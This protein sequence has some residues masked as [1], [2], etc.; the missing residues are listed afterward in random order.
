MVE[1]LDIITESFIPFA[2]FDHTLATR[3]AGLREI[4][5]RDRNENLPVLI[6]HRIMI[7]RKRSRFYDVDAISYDADSLSAAS[8]SVRKS[9]L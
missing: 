2:P 4:A 8:S 3:Q 1:C 9:M 6:T 7:E 5:S